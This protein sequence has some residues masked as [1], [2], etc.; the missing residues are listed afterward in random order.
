MTSMQFY[1]ELVG[2]PLFLLVSMAVALEVGSRLRRRHQSG[3]DEKDMEGLGVVDG[4]VFGLMGLLLAFAFSGAAARFDARRE[5]ITQEANDVGTAW[6]RVALLPEADQPAVRAKFR[7]YV[8]VRLSTFKDGVD[9]AS[10]QKSLD[11][12]GQLQNEIW[13]LCAASSARAPSTVPGMLLLTSLNEMF[14]IVTTRTAA[15]MM[16]P[17]VIVFLLLIAVLTLCSL[18]AGYRMS[19][20]SRSN[21]WTGLHKLSFVLI[22]AITYYVI[23]DLEYP[24]TGLIRV[25]DYD[26]MLVQV[27]RSMD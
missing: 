9:K 8:D 26:Q 1:L 17:P 10:V 22:L 11:R 5:L 4:A 24:R 12:A 18:L 19:G 13:A 7:E 27:R 25:D 23:V 3:D 6:L 20:S 21:H 14:D 16:H 15:L 2:M